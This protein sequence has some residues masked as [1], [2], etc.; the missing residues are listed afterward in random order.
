MTRNVTDRSRIDHGVMQKNGDA[1]HPLIASGQAVILQV[2][3]ALLGI[4][5]GVG[6]GAGGA[7][8]GFNA[9]GAVARALAVA[10]AAGG[11]LAVSGE[12]AGRLPAGRSQGVRWMTLPRV[13]MIRSMWLGSM[14]SGGDRAM[15]SP[16]QRTSRPS[17][18]QR[19]NTS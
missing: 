19:S 9:V 7:E 12:M 6:A 14:I 16:V 11:G 3:P 8:H 1:G 13:S 2:V 15:M 17:R 18:K 10:A 4:P 5:G